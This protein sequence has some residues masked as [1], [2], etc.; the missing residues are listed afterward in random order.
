[1]KFAKEDK[2]Y[3]ERRKAFS[4]ELG[5]QELFSVIDHWP[6]YAGTANL[7]RFLTNAD[8]VRQTLDVPGHV[9]EF[10]S[11]RGANLMLMAKVLKIFDPWGCKEVFCFDS[12]EGLETFTVEDGTAAGQAGTYK[13][14]L[15]QLTELLLL[16]DLDDSVSIQKGL[17]QDSLPAFF[18]DRPSTVFSLIY[19]DTDLFEPTELI[20]ESL[21]DRL[22]LGGLFVFDQWNDS[23]WP[24]ETEAAQRFIAQKGDAYEMIHPRNTR[25]PTLVLKRVLV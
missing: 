12:F 6:L 23:R 25:Q 13:G 22:S 1:M 17:I 19:C 7:A 16:Y 5:P 18:K 3:L 20:L 15:G 11:W 10:G 24:G 8:L 2:S 14:H 4:A 21:H 9:A